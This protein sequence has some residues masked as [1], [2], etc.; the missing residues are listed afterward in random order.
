MQELEA[1]NVMATLQDKQILTLAESQ[2]VDKFIS[3]M[4]GDKH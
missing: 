1:F 2:S 4:Y 3:H